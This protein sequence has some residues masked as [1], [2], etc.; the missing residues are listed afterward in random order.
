MLFCPAI[1]SLHNYLND[2]IKRSP[3]LFF[4]ERLSIFG[5]SPC[6]IQAIDN[7][8]QPSFEIPRTNKY[9]L[10]YPATTVIIEPPWRY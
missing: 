2:D 3:H 5:V 9:Y 1:C 7:D 6:I 8:Y 4:S 10:V